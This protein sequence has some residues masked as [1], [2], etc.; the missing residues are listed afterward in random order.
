[1]TLQKKFLRLPHISKTL[2]KRCIYALVNVMIGPGEF[3]LIY[4]LNSSLQLVLLLH[5]LYPL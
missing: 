5:Q 4:V 2:A 3:F 1:M